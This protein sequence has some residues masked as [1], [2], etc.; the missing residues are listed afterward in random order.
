MTDEDF[1]CSKY[2]GE[3][4]NVKRI[5][6]NIINLLIAVSL[7]SAIIVA[8][9]YSY[10]QHN[11]NLFDNEHICKVA[12]I[13]N[14]CP[15][16]KINL[17][18][19]DNSFAEIFEY[20][21]DDE[22][23]KI[24]DL[25]SFKK[26]FKCY[27]FDNKIYNYENGINIYGFFYV[28]SLVVLI[29][30]ISIILLFIMDYQYNRYKERNTKNNVKYSKL[31][32]NYTAHFNTELEKRDKSINNFNQELKK[33]DQSLDKFN[34]ELKTFQVKVVKNLDQLNKDMETARQA[35]VKLIESIE[36][37]STPSAPP[38]YGDYK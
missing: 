38:A 20:N 22:C 26:E 36:N 8:T 24:Y 33:R 14:D 35:I 4:I 31:V 2:F 18:I 3:T 27:N 28:P 34:Q 10:F 9:S 11:N 32:R 1:N 12:N 15:Y 37:S 7:I 16:V 29:T 6:L 5:K 19:D 23:S 25:Y 21:N 30:C 17:T 13:I